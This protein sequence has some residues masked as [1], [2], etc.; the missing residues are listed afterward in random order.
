MRSVTRSVIFVFLKMLVSTLLKEFPRS[1]LRPDPA[2]GLPASLAHT[3]CSRSN[4]PDLGNRLTCAVIHEEWSRGDSAGGL[5][6]VNTDGSYRGL[7]VGYERTGEAIAAV[8]SVSFLDV[9]VVRRCIGILRVYV[10][11]LVCTEVEVGERLTAVIEPDRIHLPAIDQP[12]DQCVGRSDRWH[13]VGEAD[14]GNVRKEMPLT[15]RS[16]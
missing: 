3:C 12:A 6:S 13:C 7:G 15:A 11:R 1:R 8:E 4:G 16:A 14:A 2:H 9:R 5:G 10:L